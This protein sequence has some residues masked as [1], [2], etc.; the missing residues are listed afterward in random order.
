VDRLKVP[1]LTYWI[2]PAEHIFGNLQILLA[3]SAPSESYSQKPITHHSCTCSKA[4]VNKHGLVIN[5]PTERI[6]F[7]EKDVGLNMLH[8][9]KSC[10]SAIR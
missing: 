9:S 10:I 3:R 1:V 4:I 5:L 8:S 7:Q 2:W 6:N